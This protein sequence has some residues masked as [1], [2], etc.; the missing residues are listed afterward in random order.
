MLEEVMHEVNNY[1]VKNVYKGK[2]EISNSSISLPFLA[3]GQYFKIIGSVFNDGVHKYPAINLKD[4]T[5]EGVIQALAVPTEFIKLAS[6]IQ[7]W[8]DKY[9]ASIEGPYTSESFGGYSYSKASGAD[10]GQ[11][12]WMSQFRSRLSRWRKI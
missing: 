6:D 8:L 7:G 1:F 10:G 12:T 5:F 3:E 2:F 4:E 9:G 11:I